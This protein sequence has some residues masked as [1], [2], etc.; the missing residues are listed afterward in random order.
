MGSSGSRRTARI[1]ATI[2]AVLAVGLAGVELVFGAW[3]GA[4]RLN[5]LN[6]IRNRVLTYDVSG[7][8]DSPAAAIT[9]SRDRYGLRGDYG[10][11]PA[12]IELLT[13]GGSTT[14]Q[15]A[16]GDG[17]TWQDVL[18]RRA[19]AAGRPLVVANA[20]VDGQST[21][22]HL[23]DFDWWFPSIPG[24]KPTRI[25]FFVGLND[26]HV[27]PGEPGD[28]VEHGSLV[29]AFNDRSAVWY[30]IRTA[31]GMFKAT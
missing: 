27:E 6:L 14:D 15:R 26:V 31:R 23:K 2:I 22:G 19:A 3:L 11:D 5:R 12:R 18:S 9:Y 25:L 13:I 17:A 28:A 29:A 8:Y 7:L 10:G 4:D 1:V 20:G 24:L 16:I 21:V 30:L